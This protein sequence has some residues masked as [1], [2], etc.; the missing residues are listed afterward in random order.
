MKYKTLLLWLFAFGVLFAFLQYYNWFHFFFIEQKQLFLYTIPFAADTISVTG[1]VAMYIA[2]FLLQF[3]AVPY[4]GAAISAALLTTVGVLMQVIVKR[5]MPVTQSYILYLLPVLSLLFVQFNFNYQL[6][7]TTAFILMQLFVIGYITLNT[8]YKRLTV[9]VFMVPVLFFTAGPVSVLFVL[10]TLIWEF[11]KK[12]KRGYLVLFLLVEAVVISVL[13]VYFS[14]LGEYHLAFLPD[15][16]LPPKLEPLTVVYFSWRAF[17]ACMVLAVLLH[18]RKDISGIKEKAWWGVQLLLL[19]AFGF[20][21]CKNYGDE[22][23]FKMKALDYYA[24]TE[25]WDKIIENNK[26]KINNYLNLNYLNLA[27]AHKNI[28]ADS[29]FYYDQ[30]GVVSLAVEW[31]KTSHISCLLSDIYF[32]T[33]HVSLAQQMAFEASSAESEV[34]N[35]R[36]LKRLIETNLITGAYTVAEKYISILENTLFYRNW[37]TSQ[38]VFLHNDKAV[39]ADS[40]LG[41]LRKCLPSNNSLALISGV[42]RDFLEIAQANPSRRAAVEYLGSLYLLSKEIPLFKQLV[43]T[44]YDTEVLPVLPVSFQEAVIIYAEGDSEYWRE[45]GVGPETVRRFIVFK[46]YLIENKS[47]P[48]VE[49]L[50]MQYFGNTYWYYM[51]FKKGDAK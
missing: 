32:M 19:L 31:N 51:M 23:S 16:Y 17:L 14:V 35:P 2:L 24:Y 15:F 34:G 26:G 39:E 43:E 18:K 5:I 25:Q 10:S 41:N 36:M 4:A 6:Q 27:L 47:K 38:R 40:L 22:R 8:F 1:G 29:M 28:L 46:K 21:G 42:D 37:A 11:F 12:E 30:R 49:A 50:M 45:H 44:Y 3:F 48:A 13:S 20:W 7:G 9:G 33:G